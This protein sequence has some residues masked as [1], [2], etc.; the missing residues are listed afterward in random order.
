MTGLGTTKI[1]EL[2]AEGLFPK[3]VRLTGRSVAWP[4]DE[5]AEWTA[6]RIAE[7]D[8]RRSA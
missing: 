2:A 6:A 4:E 1:Y 7:R 5:V 8:S 3:P